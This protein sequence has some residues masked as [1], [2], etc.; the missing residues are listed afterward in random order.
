MGEVHYDHASYENA[1]S[2]D[3]NKDPNFSCPGWLKHGLVSSKQQCT[4]SNCHQR[5]H[6]ANHATPS[7]S[8]IERGNVRAGGAGGG[9][10]ADGIGTGTGATSTTGAT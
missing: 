1:S 10:Y 7:G 8:R 6:S 3:P 4:N 2:G 9:D 5:C